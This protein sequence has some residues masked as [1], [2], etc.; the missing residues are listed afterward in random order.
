[1]NLFTE[2]ERIHKKLSLHTHTH[3]HAHTSSTVIL[4]GKPSFPS[5][6]P[7][8]TSSLTPSHHVLLIRKKGRR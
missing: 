5:T 4:L 1:M 2:V 8:H 3:T 6:L 7:L